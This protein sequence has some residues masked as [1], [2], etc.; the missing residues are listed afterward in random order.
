MGAGR[1]DRQLAL[2][3]FGENAQTKLANAKVLVIGAG[4]LGCPA[5]QYLA[6]A[7]VG[8]L[9][10]VDHDLIELS[11]LHRQIL[12]TTADIG[13]TKAAIAASRL[14]E[15]N[16]EIKIVPYAVQI[17]SNNVLEIL[18][19]Y[20]YVLDG[21]DNFTARYLIN[22]ACSILNKPL[23]FAAVSGYEGQLALFNVADL[24]GVT[25]NYRDIF[26]I[27]PSP[28]EIPNCEEN[29]V[30]GV[31]P[32]IIGSMAAAEVL[33]LVLGIGET[34][35]NKMLH[36][37]LLTN[38]QYEINIVPG[39]GY[40]F[41]DFAQKKN[42]FSEIGIDELDALLQQP[43]T[44]LVD[45]REVNEVPKLDPKLFRQVPMSVF[46]AYLKTE[47]HQHTIVLICQHGV[48]SV[49]AA[50]AMA[51]KYGTSK[52][53]YSLKGGISKWRNYFIAT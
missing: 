51:E 40:S 33:K 25:T 34:L 3:G 14:E 31:L 36:Y 17:S 23:F 6:A 24:N 39:S 50:E 29:G 18:S 12:Y 16:P 11:N 52:N 44:L 45:V 13:K 49:Y 7:G 48:R 19:G 27:P 15:M 26:P 42:E 32:G 35:A 47:I 43:S 4:G 20:D 37:N 28:G 2:T 10:L 53:I 21:T 41:Q 8:Y 1:Y 22:D 46:E 30:I 5:L 38:K 9:G